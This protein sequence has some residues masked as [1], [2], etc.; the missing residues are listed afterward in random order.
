MIPDSFTVLLLPRHTL[1]SGQLHWVKGANK[2]FDYHTRPRAV[3]M[4]V[5]SL[6]LRKIS[7]LRK[8]LCSVCS[9]KCLHIFAAN[10]EV[11]KHGCFQMKCV[12][13]ET[14]CGH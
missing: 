10:T 5:F 14:D 13:G 3:L 12:G 2:V 9:A 11:G 8:E 1:L 7:A 4:P 6:I